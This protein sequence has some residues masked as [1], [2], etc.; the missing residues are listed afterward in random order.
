MKK[1]FYFFVCIIALNAVIENVA[2]AGLSIAST[3]VEIVIAPLLHNHDGEPI[4]WHFEGRIDN[5]PYYNKFL[6]T[7]RNENA[8]EIKARHLGYNIDQFLH[9]ST[10]C[11]NTSMG[12]IMFAQGYPN[13]SV[14]PGKTLNKET[15][16]PIVE[17][18][19][20]KISVPE[21]SYSSIQKISHPMKR[22]MKGST[23]SGDVGH[24]YDWD[25]MTPGIIFDNMTIELFQP[26]RY[27]RV[28]RRL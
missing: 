28:E 17:K 4:K 27:Q 3:D 1:W 18:Y 6:G 5:L 25:K 11:V 10:G 9:G 21:F 22:K 16:F 12:A 7:L 19:Y 20:T 26:N 2:Y 8:E 13:A 24:F 14:L 23:I 15:L